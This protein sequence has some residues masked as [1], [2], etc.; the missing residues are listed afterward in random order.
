MGLSAGVSRMKITNK[1][2]LS[3]NQTKSRRGFTLIQMVVTISLMSLILTINISAMVSLMKKNQSVSFYA[4]HRNNMNRLSLQF[5][6]DIHQADNISIIKKDDS[7]ELIIRKN[8]FEQIV[9]KQ[10]GNILNREDKSKGKRLSTEVFRFM[11]ETTI[12]FTRDQDTRFMNAKVSSPAKSFNEQ[13]LPEGYLPLNPVHI[14][15]RIGRD[16]RFQNIEKPLDKNTEPKEGD[17]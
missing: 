14:V 5:R 9:Y 15:A 7:T 11:P 8:E 17:N 1:K 13:Y 4:V 12:E 3:R 16:L 10:S 6:K 2:I